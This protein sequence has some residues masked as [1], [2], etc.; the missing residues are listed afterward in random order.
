[1]LTNRQVVSAYRN[2]PKLKREHKELE[3]EA[4]KL[5][6]RLGALGEKIYY[7]KLVDE[8]VDGIAL[9]GNYNA[10]GDDIQRYAD[11]YLNAHNKKTWGIHF[12]RWT[13][14][15]RVYVDGWGGADNTEEEVNKWAKDWI[16]KGIL[17]D[18]VSDYDRKILLD[19]KVK[20]RFE[21]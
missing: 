3:K 5:Q 17:P 21:P 13:D 10:V 1:M 14:D 9:T 15:Y 11:I 20:D 4:A 12:K 6:R 2:L 19:T 7:A 8:I 16:V 18:C